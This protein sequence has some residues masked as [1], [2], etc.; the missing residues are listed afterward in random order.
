MS[1]VKVRNRERRDLESPKSYPA[2][3]GGD[4][5]YKGIG[6]IF[7]LLLLVQASYILAFSFKEGF[8][9]LTLI[10]FGMAAI[11]ILLLWGFFSF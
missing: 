4:M 1:F 10:A 5:K 3:S 2:F 7:T 9:S 6:T 8:S 11:P